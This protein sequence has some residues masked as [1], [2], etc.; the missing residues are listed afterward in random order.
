MGRRRG[1]TVVTNIN[2]EQEWD[3]F[4]EIMTQDS[5]GIRMQAQLLMERK[6]MLKEQQEAMRQ[7]IKKQKEEE[8]KLQQKIVRH[9]QNSK[10]RYHESES[11][12]LNDG[13]NKKMPQKSMI[14]H[15]KDNTNSLVITDN[16]PDIPDEDTTSTIDE[17]YA[18]VHTDNR[19]NN[20]NGQIEQVSDD[21]IYDET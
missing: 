15:F 10:R 4:D 1:S 9:R 13:N 7:K 3:D 2:I 17:L 18:S 11:L 16:I 19:N 20:G 5:L 8:Q 12:S 6:L 14:L 21:D